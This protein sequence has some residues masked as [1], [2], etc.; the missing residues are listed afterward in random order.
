MTIADHAV[1]RGELVIPEL[2]KYHQKNRNALL[3]AVT[4]SKK[5]HLPAF[6]Y[7]ALRLTAIS[8]TIGGA[9]A[10]PRAASVRRSRMPSAIER[11]RIDWQWWPEWCYRQS[12]SLL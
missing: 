5:R 8:R 1:R 10:N 11:Y 4:S 3:L 12:T 7:T 6:V 2:Q 9:P